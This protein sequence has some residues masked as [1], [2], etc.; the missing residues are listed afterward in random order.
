MLSRSLSGFFVAVPI[1]ILT[2][3]SLAAADTNE[4]TKP[5]DGKWEEPFWSLG[6]LPNS[7][8]AIHLINA[9][10]KIVV[11][12]AATSQ[13]QPQSLSISQ[14]VIT[15][16]NTLLLNN[17]GLR[18]VTIV[19]STNRWSNV[20]ISRDGTLIN[21]N[22]VFHLEGELNQLKI[23][24]GGRVFQ[25]GGSVRAVNL[26][27][28]GS[29]EYHL[30]NGLLE[31]HS[32]TYPSG[33]FFFQYGGHVVAQNSG[34]TF[35][36]YRL[37]EGELLVKESLRVGDSAK[38]L[39]S[40]GTNRSTDLGVAPNSSGNG[41]YQLSGGLLATSN[42]FVGAFM[43]GSRIRQSGG[44]YVVTNK[45]TLQGSSRYYPPQSITA[46]YEL[47][48]GTFSAKTV[49]LD[50]RYG[51]P[52]FLQKG[53]EATIA[54]TLQ[55]N[56]PPSDLNVDMR[57]TVRLEGGSLACAAIS[58]AGVG[59]DI[60]QTGGNLIV[61]N[62]LSLSGSYLPRLWPA[63]TRL[64]VRY[65]FAAGT[66]TA[67]DIEIEG[68][69]V[70]GSSNAR[71]R[72]NNPGTFKLGGLLKAGDTDENLG[73]FVLSTNS[74]FDLGAGNAKLSFANSAGEAWNMAST[75]TITNWAS[76]GAGQDRLS[77]GDNSAGLTREQLETV[78]FI[79]PGG[80]T[81]GEYSAKLLPNG[82]LVPELMRT[83]SITP[84]PN[85]FTLEWMA[86]Y[87]LQTSTNAAGPYEDIVSASSPYPVPVTEEPRRFFRLKA[88]DE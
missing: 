35:G 49:E 20:D 39:Q 79:N 78:I 41:E 40:G 66:L 58:S 25:S 14:L 76:I 2:A 65:D 61:S 57:G 54:D 82:E 77:F 83:I 68:E 50:G 22:S 23:G 3:S 44:V 27:A 1:L 37:E 70:I 51:H 72:I 74:V 88:E 15:G 33:A 59:A 36:T 67:T 86:P 30:T 69:L 60:Q 17:V 55:L 53:G 4:W 26:L 47:S 12:D 5:T 75:L 9:G 84:A 24:T 10:E 62:L 64:P 13:L 29:G 21:L 19:E 38:F 31:V 45:L 87:R 85:A 71:E 16:K 56:L 43:D 73:R 80:Y 34:F 63:G 42:T 48:S 18:A 7:D 52:E 11:I 46:R 6:S 32:L 28:V 8:Q 81:P